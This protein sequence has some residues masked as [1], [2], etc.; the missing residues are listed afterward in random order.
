M[1]QGIIFN[2]QRFSIHDGPGIRTTVF[3]KGCPLDCVWCHNPESKRGTPQLSWAASRCIG[4]R[5]CEAV[6][7]N[8]VHV[9]G[10]QGKAVLF[11]QC[12]VCGAC[13]EACPAAALEIMGREVSAE[14]VM[15]EVKSDLPFYENSGGGMTL[16]GGEPAMQST[17]AE[18]LLRQAKEAGIHTAIETAGYI[19]WKVYERLLP[20]LDLI[21]FDSK[22][23]DPEK[24][25]R[26]TGKS[27]EK[28]HE[29]LRRLCG[30]EK[31]VEVIV[32][33]PVIPGYNDEKENFQAL[34][35]FLNSLERIPRV[36]LLP[37]NT[38]AGSKHPRLGL[39]YTPEVDEN[40]GV[41]PQELCLILQD[42]GIHAKIAG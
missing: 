32:R 30:K 18:E 3:L 31:T 29:N 28:I 20:Y 42:A 14:E 15:E 21:L 4:C 12:K 5:R 16:S 19:D 36:E 24:H 40:A 39:V 34:A 27:N 33:T 6:C 10:E 13:V 23:M 35:A 9:Y 7:A 8:G 26:Y 17:F 37:Y 1:S 11:D 41:S 25:R 38:L 2:I 22:Q